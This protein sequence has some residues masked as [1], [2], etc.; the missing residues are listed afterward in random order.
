MRARACAS[1]GSSAAPP[2][3]SSRGRA[4]G[5]ALRWR[6]SRTWSNTARRIAASACCAFSSRPGLAATVA[7]LLSGW[8]TMR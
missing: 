5:S 6:N 3:T 7:T 1:S 2:A 4:F 8:A